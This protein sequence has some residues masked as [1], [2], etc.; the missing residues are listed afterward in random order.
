MTKEERK[1]YNKEYHQNLYKE[2]KDEILKNSKKYR[3][4]NLEKSRESSRKSYEKYKTKRKGSQL[5][6]KYGI[7]LDEYN[8]LLIKQNGVC[9]I[10]S[11]IEKVK[12]KNGTL[13][14]LSVDHDHKT[15][16]VRGLLCYKCNSLLG[17]VN[18]SIYILDKAK[19]YLIKNQ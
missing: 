5:K 13:L 14:Q 12:H 8:E 4:N 2:N 7:T 3:E 19:E 6:F 9:D 18:D 10:C 1:K 16:K 17:R 15:G 11:Q